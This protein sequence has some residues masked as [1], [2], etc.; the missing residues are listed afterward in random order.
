MNHL[1]FGV[2]TGLVF[3]ALSVAIMIPLKLP[4]KKAAMIASFLN[5]FAIGLI[6]PL[7]SLDAPA[8]AIGAAVGLLVSLPEA[9]ITKSYLP[10]IG[11]GVLGG[12]LVG[13]AS[14]LWAA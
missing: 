11:F 1:L 13:F 7:I 2:I 8:W 12:L 6:I 10:I 14:G 9:V 3:G 5:R 4:D